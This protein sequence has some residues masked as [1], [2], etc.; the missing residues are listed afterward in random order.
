MLHHRFDSI[1]FPAYGNGCKLTG[2]RRLL[3]RVLPEQPMP[4]WLFDDQS[5]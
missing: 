2:N 4:T 1:T 3:G 5:R